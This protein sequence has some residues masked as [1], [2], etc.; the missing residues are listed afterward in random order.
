M[1]EER[2]SSVIATRKKRVGTCWIAGVASVESLGDFEGDFLYLGRDA[3]VV[4]SQEV[5]R[6]SR[7]TGSD[8]LARTSHTRPVDIVKG[9]TL[10][11]PVI[12]TG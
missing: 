4:C 5:R 11:A 9:K 12:S 3:C 8:R 7:R 1:G 2:S 6:V 10:L